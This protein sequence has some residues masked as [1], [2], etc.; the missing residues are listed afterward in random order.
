MTNRNLELGRASRE[1]AIVNRLY[2]IRLENR[3][4]S[5]GADPIARI[6]DGMQSRSDDT[7]NFIRGNGF[8]QETGQPQAHE[9]LQ[10]LLRLRSQ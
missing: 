6:S 8:A 5:T 2:L 10:P 9:A 3:R 4:N 1:P 7:D